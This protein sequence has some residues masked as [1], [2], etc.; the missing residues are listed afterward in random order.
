MDMDDSSDE[1]LVVRYRN[2]D[3]P[4]FRSLVGRYLTPV[5][6]FV[7]R[8][9]GNE[10]DAADLTQDVFVAVWK[11]LAR[12]DAD[13][14]FK[15]W[16]F[17][18]AKNTSLNWLKRKKPLLFS[19]FT[20]PEGENGLA[21]SLADPTQSPEVLLTRFDSSSRLSAA[22]SSLGAM[23]RSVLELRYTDGFTFRE[24]ARSLGEP[25]HTV[26]SRH[27]RALQS[28]RKTLSD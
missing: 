5:Y 14:Q 23:Y 2:G 15:T 28:L 9:V 18:I 3:E 21:E 12:F 22:L 20:T 25:L 24:I 4:A 13:R 11:N 6:N 1:Q 17:A 26:K 16:L 10:G 8:Y 19:Q 27:R 7:H